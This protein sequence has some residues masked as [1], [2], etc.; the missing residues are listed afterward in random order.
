MK[1]EYRVAWWRDSGY[2][3]PGGIRIARSGKV[4]IYQREWTAQRFFDWLMED[5]KACDL[6]RD[7][8]PKFQYGNVPVGRM[9]G[10]TVVD[11]QIQ[12][13]PVG[14]WEFYA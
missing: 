7:D 12:R 4:K 10:R 9:C 2:T 5:C 8:L 1:Y 14:E 6:C 11:A 13:R 3:E